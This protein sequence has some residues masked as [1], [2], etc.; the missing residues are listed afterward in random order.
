M[1]TSA[2]ED[3][4][5]NPK[6]KKKEEMMKRIISLIVLSLLLLSLTG[7]APCQT[8]EEVVK[9]MIQA[10]GGED[11][12]ANI[13]DSTFAGNMEMIQ[14]GITGAVTMYQK[15]PNMM[16]MDAEV[17]GMTITQAFD[18]ETAW[19]TNPQTGETT[20]MPE[21]FAAYMRRQALGNDSLLNPE[22]YGIT[23]NY[24]GKEKIEEKEYLALE[25]SYADGY[26]ATVYLDPGTY[27][28]YKSKGVA[29]NQMGVE[30]EQESLLSDY[31]E[32]E[33]LMIP[34]AITTYQDGE[35]FMIITLTEVS[36]NSGLEDSLF[37]MNQ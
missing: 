12:L 25:Q 14:M 24:R 1:I 10:Q 17:M 23:F 3:Q 15:E 9:K 19:T 13:E 22:K 37:K 34:H 7:V 18:G 29:L 21:K 2:L 16:R 31:K 30:V 28:V 27:L 8:T 11:T 35:K 26:K 32:V 6:I 20:E 4:K 33:G 5:S 36:F